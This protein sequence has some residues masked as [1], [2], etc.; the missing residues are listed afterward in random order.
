MEII[1][2]LIFIGGIV[3]SL[4]E[5]SQKNKQKK[6]T[7]PTFSGKDVKDP[8]PSPH[9]K[10]SNTRN[11]T[12]QKGLNQDNGS[13]S[14]E[15]RGNIFQEMLK[16]IE[17]EINKEL[18]TKDTGKPLPNQSIPKHTKLT[19]KQIKDLLHALKKQKFTQIDLKTNDRIKKRQKELHDIAKSYAISYEQLMNEVVPKVL[20][21]LPVDEDGSRRPTRNTAERQSTRKIDEIQ[22][23]TRDQYE[24]DRN[25]TVYNRDKKQNGTQEK[26]F[27]KQHDLTE[28]P[29][30]QFSQQEVIQGMI[31]SEILSPPKS[32]QRLKR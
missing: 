31:M 10:S 3:Y 14:S 11:E 1:P 22:R 24:I 5:S 15:K 27:I 30:L 25:E 2:I 16:E 13:N 19:E 6:N 23:K 17:N 29:Q 21:R 7:M 4:I 26:D 32:K 9:K 12:H 8:K 18:D 20:N 28:I